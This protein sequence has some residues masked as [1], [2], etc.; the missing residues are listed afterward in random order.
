ML[1]TKCK[2]IET[3]LAACLGNAEVAK[4]LIEIIHCVD[5]GKSAP[6]KAVKCEAKELLK[7]VMEEIAELKEFREKFEA[8]ESQL[9]EMGD[10]LA[11]MSLK[12][13]EAMAEAVAEVQEESKK[14]K[15][16]T[17]KDAANKK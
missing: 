12:M 3:E 5:H 17:K 14:T 13:N 8:V 4:K 15:K 10:N 2:A 7:P 16:V 1:D 11:V 9:A 6:A